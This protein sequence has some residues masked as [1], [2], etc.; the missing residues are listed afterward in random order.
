MANF[1]ADSMGKLV[2]SS[3]GEPFD[4]DSSH[5]MSACVRFNSYDIDKRNR[6]TFWPIQIGEF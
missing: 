6:S 3:L 5:R 1:I 2:V 4:A